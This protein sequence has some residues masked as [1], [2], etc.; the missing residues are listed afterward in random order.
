MN[1]LR[2]TTDQLVTAIL[3]T[4]INLAAAKLANDADLITEYSDHL[5]YL[6]DQ[7]QEAT[8]EDVSWAPAAAL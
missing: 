2:A 4:K 5:E 1:I 7:W 3:E 8:E 6:G